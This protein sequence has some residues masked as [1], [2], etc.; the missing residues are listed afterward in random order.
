MNIAIIP[1]RYHSTR[2]IGK[3]L[4]EIGGIPMI[5]RVCRQVALSKIEKIIVATDDKRII[6]I[7]INNG[8]DA[9][10]TQNT[11]TSGTERCGEVSQILQLKEK[12][13]VINIQGDEPFIAPE[14]IDLLIDYYNKN[15]AHNIATLIQTSTNKEHVQNPNRIKVVLNQQNQALYFSRQAIPFHRNNNS[16]NFPYNIHNGLYAYDVDTLRKIIALPIHA[17]ELAEQLEQLRWL[18]N[19]FV[20][21]CLTTNTEHLLGID[22]LEDLKRAEVFITNKERI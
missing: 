18:A 19:G 22:T 3:P 1:A 8:F 15:N 5:I 17:L 6:D 7:V 14:S 20:I 16:A 12:D 9:I 21:Q 13:I 4:L 10:K 2:L 11:H